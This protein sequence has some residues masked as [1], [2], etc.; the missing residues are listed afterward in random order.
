MII[1]GKIISAK[2]RA[3]VG[4][5]VFDHKLAASTGEAE[6]LGLVAELNA[7]A[8]VDGILVQFPVPRQIEA[9]RVQEAISPEK[10]VDGLHPASA[11][12]LWAGRPT[13]VPCTP[14]GVM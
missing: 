11:G 9:T 7:D 2:V 8:R 5:E 1:D 10:D 4:I 3:E 12:R 13:F 14:M 6:L